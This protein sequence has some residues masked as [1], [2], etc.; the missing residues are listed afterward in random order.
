[1]TPNPPTDPLRAIV[2][3]CGL[4]RDADDRILLVH[5]RA[6]RA[7][8]PHLWDLPGGEAL[9]DEDVD[10]TVVR[11]LRE[12]LGIQVQEHEFV[13]TA[14]AREPE[15]G[16]RVVINL[17]LIH[18][19]NG[20]PANSQPQEHDALEWVAPA[21]VAARDLHP[22]VMQVLHP[23][24]G[25]PG[26]APVDLIDQREAWNAMSAP[27]QEHHAIS[28]D[29]IHYGA[30]IPTEDDLRLVGD[31]QGRDVIEVGCGGGQNAVVFKQRGA[32]RVAG[33]D[34]S[35]AQ[36]AYARDLALREGVEV[37]FYQGSVE[38]LRAFSDASFDVAFSA[39]CFSYVP[40][41]ARTM[42]EV[43]R[44]LRPGG[45]FAF[46]LDHP[47]V[48]MTGED[49]V[50]FQRSYFDREAEWLWW[51]PSGAATRMTAIYRTLEELFDT[52][53]GAGFV[54]D[55]VLEPRHGAPAGGRWDEPMYTQTRFPAT[56]ILAAHKPAAGETL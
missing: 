13:E 43:F 36:I 6:G 29:Q 28:L 37:E 10:D 16:R 18:D 54:A 14:Y 24:L 15:S 8:W 50:T 7:R 5:C 44:V 39:Y 11:E 35:D 32:R 27:Y 55:R 9:D 40:D 41:L 52:L 17:Y 31:F 12:E 45:R 56:I 47:L 19:Y 38:N 3:C 51:F 1:M 20:T 34:L 21:E 46:S 25:L 23:L 2:T 4:I 53:R 48:G 26:E 33:I 30:N 22:A 42:Q 49:G